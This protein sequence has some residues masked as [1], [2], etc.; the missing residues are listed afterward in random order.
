VIDDES[1]ALLQAEVSLYVATVDAA[2]AP[3]AER[4][5]ALQVLDG[6]TRVRVSVPADNLVLQANLAATGAVAITCNEIVS[7]QAVQVKGR[8]AGAAG[9]ETD[10]DRARREA[11]VTAFVRVVHDYMGTSPDIIDRRMPR[12]FVV[13]NVAVEEVYDQTPGPSAGRRLA[14]A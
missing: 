8:V 2:G 14:P 6:G 7:N 10:D 5:F 13:F 9:P 1:A 3:D 4:A 11:H 12:E